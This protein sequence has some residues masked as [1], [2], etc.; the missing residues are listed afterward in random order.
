MIMD[1]VERWMNLAIESGGIMA[2][3]K[4]GKKSRVRAKRR[5]EVDAD[6]LSVG[7]VTSAD[8]L[9]SWHIK[10]A[11]GVANLRLDNA[12]AALERQLHAPKAPGGKLR[13]L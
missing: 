7:G 6:D 9:V 8:V 3:P 4:E 5:I 2:R 12:L 13:Q 1:R 11:L 10:G